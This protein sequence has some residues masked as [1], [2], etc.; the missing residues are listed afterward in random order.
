LHATE[1]EK[2][3]QAISHRIDIL[4]P[5]SSQVLNYWTQSKRRPFRARDTQNP[6]AK[7]ESPHGDQRDQR[8][9]AASP[10]GQGNERSEVI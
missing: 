2:A 5:L 10:A 3:A 4:S 8:E 9:T 7:E 6:P 1:Q